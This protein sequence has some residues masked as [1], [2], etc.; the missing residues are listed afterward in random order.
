M[1]ICLTS[2]FQE[3]AWEMPGVEPPTGWPLEGTVQFFNY[4]TRYRPGLGLV[5]DNFTCSIRNNEKVE[6]DLC[7]SQI[8][9]YW[10][11][12]QFFKNC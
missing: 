4:R 2:A 6:S 9:L 12:T 8:D 10:Q 1:L 5:L 7:N 3:A 11:A